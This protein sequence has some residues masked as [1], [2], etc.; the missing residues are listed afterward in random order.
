MWRE[1]APGRGKGH[2]EAQGGSMPSVFRLSM[3]SSDLFFLLQSVTVHRSFL[4]YTKPEPSQSFHTLWKPAL[5]L[6]HPL[7]TVSERHSLLLLPYLAL[8]NSSYF[9]MTTLHRDCSLRATSDQHRPKSMVCH[10]PDIFLWGNT[11]LN[12]YHPE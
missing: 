7:V 11:V 8:V 1:R 10:P 4:C 6:F 2:A 12:F 3:D 9:S 5:H